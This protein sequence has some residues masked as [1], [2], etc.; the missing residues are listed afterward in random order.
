MP[1][2]RRGPKA[3]IGAAVV[4]ALSPLASAAT[5][6][7][8]SIASAGVEETGEDAGGEVSTDETSD[9]NG[10]AEATAPIR[11]PGTSACVVGPDF[12]PSTASAETDFGV[13]R[14]RVRAI[15]AYDPNAEND[16]YNYAD[17]T[18]F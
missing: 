14:A 16:V 13:N 9:P 6:F 3:A 5:P 11:C 18:S 17:A 15:A 2:M 12:I 10:T 8:H 4:L 7:V 1:V